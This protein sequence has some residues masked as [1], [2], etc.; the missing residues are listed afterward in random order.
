MLTDKF[1]HRDAI[2]K[3]TTKVLMHSAAPTMTERTTTPNS[4]SPGNCNSEG[5][6]EIPPRAPSP[7]PLLR[8]PQLPSP[9]KASTHIDITVRFLVTTRL[10]FVRFRK[11]SNP[12]KCF[13]S[14]IFHQSL[15]PEQPRLTP[16]ILS[17]LRIEGHLPQRG[18]HGHQFEDCSSS[19]IPCMLTMITPFSSQTLGGFQV[20]FRQ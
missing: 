15:H 18:V 4:I 6:Q 8:E 5:N 19:S 14:S 12:H 2:P 3:G 10:Q 11:R 13:L 7:N 9:Y 20:G 1:V 16:D 17:R